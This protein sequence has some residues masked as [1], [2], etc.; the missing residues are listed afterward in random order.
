[1]L[2]FDLFA[3]PLTLFFVAGASLLAGM[4]DAIAGGGGLIL[5]PAL[6]AAYPLA[7]P[8]TLLG[9]NKSASVWG[10]GWA[11]WRYAR[12]LNLLWR[13][14]LP[15]C[16]CAALA[17][18]LGAQL[19]A[20]LPVHYLRR[21]LPFVLLA[22]L[23]YTLWQRQMGL[24]SAPR[25]SPSA[26]AKRL[27]AWSLLIGFYDGLLGPGT[28]SFLVFAFT[29][30]LGHD[31]LQASAHAKCIN[32]GANVGALILF[33]AHGHIVWPLGIVL[34][35]SNLAGSAIGSAL[36]LRLGARFVRRVFIFVVA[37][38]IARTFWDAM[39]IY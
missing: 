28:G 36:A 27:A 34:A 38:L 9:T 1:M 18:G 13:G 3:A 15:A 11:A 12:S 6:F 17:A 25:F 22:L 37:A 26:E 30:H 20:A 14:L 2:E 7:H 35:A 33:G 31:F 10:T 29:R 39:R 8:A 21:A 19:S 23:L 4:I 5:V 16:L 24:Q 32:V